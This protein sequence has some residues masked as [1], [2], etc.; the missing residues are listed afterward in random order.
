MSIS[1]KLQQIEKLCMESWWVILFIIGCYLCYEHGLKKRNSEFAKLHQQ[2]L[3]LKKEKEIVSA[4]QENLLMQI[5]SQSDPE[6]I[7][8]VLMKGLG[9]TPEG[10]TKVLFTDQQ[11]LVNPKD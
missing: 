5:N 9:L 2:F 3:D 6:W 7:E 1:V 4:L 8:L 11:A 10:Q